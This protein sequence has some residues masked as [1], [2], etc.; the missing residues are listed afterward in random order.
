MTEVN[1]DAWRERFDKHL[2]YTPGDDG[3]VSILILKGHL[4]IEESVND[5]LKKMVIN[6]KALD[7]A[8]LQMHHKIHI[9]EAI[10]FLPGFVNA[11]AAVSA[12]N[13]LRNR[14]AHHLDADDIDRLSL[15]FVKAVEKDSGEI[16]ADRPLY[17]RLHFSLCILYGN[18]NIVLNMTVQGGASTG[19]LGTGPAPAGAFGSR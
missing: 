12:L 9:L 5:I 13:K 4:L 2:A 11:V 10:F 3:D 8:N 7:K 14:L 1:L 17:T 16:M 19:A 15:A 18:L 6:P